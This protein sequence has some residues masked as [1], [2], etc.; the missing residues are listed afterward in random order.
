MSGLP[1]WFK[2]TNMKKGK[3]LLEL[4]L[5]YEGKRAMIESTI[6]LAKEVLKHEN[7]RKNWNNILCFNCLIEAEY[8]R[9]HTKK[10]LLKH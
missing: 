4:A 1:H 10:E 6:E 5:K 3:S 7:K 8:L 9:L 2:L